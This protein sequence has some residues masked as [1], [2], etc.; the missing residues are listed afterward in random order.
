MPSWEDISACD[1]AL[2]ADNSPGNLNAS[3]STP[4]KLERPGAFESWLI[5]CP[6]CERGCV[7]CGQTGQVTKWRADEAAYWHAEWARNPNLDIE[8]GPEIDQC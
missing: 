3:D 2:Y 8:L 4:G 1:L 5:P 7:F 6:C